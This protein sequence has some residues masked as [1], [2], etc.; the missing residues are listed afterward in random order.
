MALNK[1]TRSD[2]VGHSIPSFPFG[3]TRRQMISDV[4]CHLRPLIAHMVKDIG[5][6]MPSSPFDNINC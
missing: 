5:S 4:T 6:G 1:N 3:S 2:D